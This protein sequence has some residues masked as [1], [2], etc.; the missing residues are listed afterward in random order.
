M[1]F[2]VYKFVLLFFLFGGFASAEVPRYEQI[3]RTAKQVVVHAPTLNDG[4]LVNALKMAK[5]LDIPIRVITTDD[6]VMQRNGLILTLIILEVP[7]FQ[8]PVGGDKRYFFEVETKTGWQAFDIS[9]GRPVAKPMIHYIEF[10][11]WYSKNARRLLKY[12][13]ELATAVWVKAHLG[14]QLTFTSIIAAPPED[15]PG[16]FNLPTKP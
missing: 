15:Q 4:H 14:Y 6:G 3:I 9:Q 5:N 11:S 10:N 2:N 8:V 16:I 7:V 13:P 12:V 1:Y